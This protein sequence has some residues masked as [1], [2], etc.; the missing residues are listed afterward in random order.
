MANYSSTLVPKGCELFYDEVKALRQRVINLEHTE[1]SL[2][3]SLK[4]LADVKFALDQSSIV[5]I[6]DRAGVITYVNDKF[7]EISKYTAAEL[8]GQTHQIVNSGYHPKAFFA[9]MWATITEGRVWQGEI[10]NRAKD[11]TAYWVDTTIVPF[12]DLQGK[13]YQYVAIRNDITACKQ[14]KEALQQLNEQLEARVE[15]RTAALQASQAN[16]QQHAN[17]LSQTLQKLQETQMQLIQS[18]KMS[19]L[20]QLV[21]GIAHEINNPVNFIYG[22]L[23]HADEYTHDLLR[24]VQLYQQHYPN[25]HAEIQEHLAA[26]DLAFLTEDLSKL[27]SSMKLGA[28]RIQKIVLSLRNFSRMDEAD[29]KEVHLHEGIDSTLMI[30]QNRLK[31]KG[32]HPGIQVLKHYGNL[33]LIECYP[34]QLNQVF[35]NILSNAIDALEEKIEQSRFANEQNSE[36]FTPTITIQTTVLNANQIQIAIAD[37]GSGMPPTIQRRLFDPFFTTKP[38]G[39]GTGMG[40]S[41]SYQII[42]EKH[43]GTLI[44]QS[45]QHQGTTLIATIPIRQEISDPIACST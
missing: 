21:A 43:Q 45:A 23:I 13:P 24:L 37:N 6:T 3:R 5:A 35:M 40:L 34:G 27:L 30:L 39:K 26:L 36:P 38:I 33:P 31:P 2:Q 16:L 14:T 7:C 1:Q 28:D 22:N 15:E 32:D 20:G 12:L 10:K 25:P 9:D 17:E 29:V 19:S 8:I 42:T 41:I 11:G 44:C 4:E 18:E